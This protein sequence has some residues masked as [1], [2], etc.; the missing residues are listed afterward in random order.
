MSSE[1]STS[2]FR[3]SAFGLVV[4]KA[5]KAFDGVLDPDTSPT[6]QEPEAWPDCTSRTPGRDGTVILNESKQN[7]KVA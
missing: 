6:R 1:Y 5:T 3:L 2:T 4:L 7:L